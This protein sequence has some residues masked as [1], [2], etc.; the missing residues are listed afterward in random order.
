MENRRRAR[1]DIS[2]KIFVNVGVAFLV[3]QI[4]KVH[5]TGRF[6]L[7]WN[8]LIACLLAEFG[9]I[10]GCPGAVTSIC[11]FIL[12]PGIMEHSGVCQ[13]G[14]GL[15]IILHQPLTHDEGIQQYAHAVRRPVEEAVRHIEDYPLVQEVRPVVKVA[16]Y[17]GRQIRYSSSQHSGFRKWFAVM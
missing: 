15:G 3:V 2:R 17:S 9:I 14:Q 8:V 10:S 12:S 13:N 11:P 6:R 4:V 5:Q 1:P 7:V 16:L